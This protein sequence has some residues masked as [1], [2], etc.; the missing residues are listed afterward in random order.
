MKI[1]MIARIMNSGFL[2]TNLCEREAPIRWIILP[3]VA[4]MFYPA[5]ANSQSVEQNRFESFNVPTD[6]WIIQGDAEVNPLKAGSFRS[7]TGKSIL[8]GE[9]LPDG[10]PVSFSSIKNYSDIMVEFDIL[11]SHNAS[12]AVFLQGQYGVRLADSWGESKVN[13]TTNGAI[14]PSGEKGASTIGYLPS[15]NVSRAPGTWQHVKMEFEA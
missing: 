7:Q 5:L 3:I 13:F 12:G 2:S 6:G 9:A 10:S 4:L 15:E 1:Y 14:I 11:M 8:V